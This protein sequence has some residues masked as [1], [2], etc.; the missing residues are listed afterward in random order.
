VPF[1]SE[2]LRVR[3]IG[4]KLGDIVDLANISGM[5]LQSVSRKRVKTCESMSKCKMFF[6]HADVSTE[7]LERHATQWT[8][9]NIDIP[10]CF[11]IAA[12]RLST[13][14]QDPLEVVD[15]RVTSASQNTSFLNT[16]LIAMRHL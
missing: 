4:S 3:A 9:A 16:R 14:R 2:P 6:R 11:C 7:I 13:T 8:H 1:H 15:I 5:G 12:S 10:S